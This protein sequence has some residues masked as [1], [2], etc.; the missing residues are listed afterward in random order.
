M[1]ISIKPAIETQ[2]CCSHTQETSFDGIRVLEKVSAVALGFFAATASPLL[3]GASFVAG[4]FI[5]LTQENTTPSHSHGSSCSSGF[6]E[7][8]TGIQAPPVIGL[9]SNL[10]M[11]YCHID[12]HTQ[13]VVPIIGVH[14]GMWVGN[15]AKYQFHHYKT[16][17]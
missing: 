5:G 15:L 7:Q 16:I 4:V 3:F 14:L 1:S 8:I 2:S 10:L 9:L 6:I 13:F 17:A 11:T 12:H